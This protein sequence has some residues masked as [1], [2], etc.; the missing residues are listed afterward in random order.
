MLAAGLSFSQLYLFC[1]R[2]RRQRPPHAPARRKMFPL[3]LET[4][5]DF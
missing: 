2:D 4:P 3:F 5:M 1:R